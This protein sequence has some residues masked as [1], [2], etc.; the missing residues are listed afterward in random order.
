[1]SVNLKHAIP[2]EKRHN[3]WGKNYFTIDFEMSD[4][5]T[6]SQYENQYDKYAV[7]PVVGVIEIGNH[8]IPMTMK[9]LERMKETIYDAM[10]QVEAAYR[11]GKLK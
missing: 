6:A 10:Y 11:L 3:K 1:M 5:L 4:K 2:F 8:K 7:R 9:E